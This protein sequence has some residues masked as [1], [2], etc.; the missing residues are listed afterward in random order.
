MNRSHLVIAFCLVGVLT[1]AGAN[2]LATNG[3][4]DNYNG[5]NTRKC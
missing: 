1:M 4:D 5:N 3:S 2:T